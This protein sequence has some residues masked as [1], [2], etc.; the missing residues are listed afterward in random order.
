MNTVC[1]S[2]LFA[3][4]CLSLAACASTSETKAA[5]TVRPPGDEIDSDYVAAVERATKVA[6]VEV[7]WVNPP[8]EKDRDKQD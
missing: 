7:V 3:A 4:L 8:R 5:G 6:G 1:K 2:V